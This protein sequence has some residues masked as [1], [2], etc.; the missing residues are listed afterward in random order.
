MSVTR[1]T[2]NRKTPNVVIYRH[3]NKRELSSPE[4]IEL[5]AFYKEQDKLIQEMTDRGAFRIVCEYKSLT[6]L[7][8]DI[9]FII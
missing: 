1:V 6:G 5:D 8:G 2:K 9:E 3:G 7:Y 4:D